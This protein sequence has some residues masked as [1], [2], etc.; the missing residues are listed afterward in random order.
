MALPSEEQPAVSGMDALQQERAKLYQ[1]QADLMKQIEERSKPDPSAFWAAMARGFGN[2]A[3]PSFAGGAAGLGGG[4][5]CDR[6][7]RGRSGGDLLAVHRL[8]AAGCG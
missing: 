4:R 3:T 7:H 6:D 2:P 5:P 8:V 1:I